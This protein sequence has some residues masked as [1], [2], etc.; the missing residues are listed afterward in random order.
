MG[1]KERED[2]DFFKKYNQAKPRTT[3]PLFIF[4][5]KYMADNQSPKN[6][7]TYWQPQLRIVAKLSSWIAIPVI[8]A[9]FLGKWLDKKYDTEPWLFLATVG[10]AFIISMFGLVKNALTEFKKISPHNDK[11]NLE[12][13]KDDK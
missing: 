9:T 12:E 11:N 8:L 7:F 2:F 10:L 3:L 4:R 6:I 13:S 5:Q 1:Y